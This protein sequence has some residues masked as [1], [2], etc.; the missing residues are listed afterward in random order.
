MGSYLHDYYLKQIL[1]EMA[2]TR[3]DLAAQAYINSIDTPIRIIVANGPGYGDQVFAI[4]LIRHLRLALGYQ[5]EIHLIAYNLSLEYYRAVIKKDPHY[6]NSFDRFYTLLDKTSTMEKIGELLGIPLI[7]NTTIDQIVESPDTGPLRLIDAITFRSTNNIPK[8]ELAIFASTTH[9]IDICYGLFNGNQNPATHLVNAK[10]VLLMSPYTGYTFLNP[11][12]AFA[13]QVHGKSYQYIY[14][15]GIVP[16]KFPLPTEA[17]IQHDLSRL[18]PSL[19]PLI[20]AI[21]HKQKEI[22]TS[23]LYGLHSRFFPE[24][25]KNLF[26]FITAAALHNQPLHK[27]LL[28]LVLNK[29][30]EKNWEKLLEYFLKPGSFPQRF[31]ALAL[32]LPEIHFLDATHNNTVT[33]DWGNATYVLRLPA[34]PT[35]LFN[36]L[37]IN[38][39]LL[40]IY[41]GANSDDL[42]RTAGKLGL[43]CRAHDYNNYLTNDLP[44]QLTHA[45]IC[46]DKI[47]NPNKILYLFREYSKTE[48]DRFTG[49]SRFDI[50]LSDVAAQ[51]DCS[52][53]DEQCAFYKQGNPSLLLDQF[54]LTKTIA[55]KGASYGALQAMIERFLCYAFNMQPDVARGWA[56]CLLANAL[57]VSESKLSTMTSLMVGLGTLAEAYGILPSK[58]IAMLRPILVFICLTTSFIQEAQDFDPETL[59]FVSLLM[60]TAMLSKTVGYKMME[61][62]LDFAAQTTM[63][64]F[65]KSN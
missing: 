5:G 32:K 60:L 29:I 15:L 52:M 62:T 39:T 24:Q 6:N 40:R 65:R 4:N 47:V 53:P 55:F 17:A 36:S 50:A 44:T 19:K 58:K 13:Y 57:R 64:R 41:E 34:L 14:N 31:Q 8:T 49:P 37:F 3:P 27:P 9:S 42:S 61:K 43:P 35:S 28:I 22:D 20:N 18:A 16:Y 38:S 23:F 7:A 46:K 54:L 33:T 2:I 59:L 10:R 45:N 25:D 30:N 21:I 11:N 51:T 63:N 1:A 48:R 26:S 56:H 12:V